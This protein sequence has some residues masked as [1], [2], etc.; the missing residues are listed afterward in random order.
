MI[1]T[2]QLEC[3]ALNLHVERSELA[4]DQLLS[5]ASRANPKRGFLFVSKVL[6]KHI[7]CA[8]SKM[9]EVYDRLAARVGTSASGTLV[10]GMAET[11]TGLG[12]GVAHS[13]SQ[14]PGGAVL[15]Q[16]TT[17]HAL[18]C[19]LLIT[20]DEAHSHAP[21][22]LLYEPLPE[23]MPHYLT[24]TR[25]VLVDD[26]ITTGRTLKE[27]AVALLRKLQ[28]L[29]GGQQLQELVFVSIV[30][31]LSAEQRE[32]LQDLIPAPIRFEALLE[33]SFS[34]VPNP[35]FSPSLPGQIKALD[36][37]TSPRNDLGRRGLLLS[38]REPFE[39]N[40]APL[41]LSE[42]P[43]DPARPVSVIGTGELAFQPFLL[44]EQLEAQGFEVL[45][46][47]TTRSPVLPGAAI[48]RSLHFTDEHGE[49]VSNYLH[50]PPD[51]DRQVIVVYESQR[52]AALH[53]L[54]KRLPLTAWVLPS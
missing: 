54:S 7:P 12:A 24:A 43:L 21:D 47:S 52:S 26:E 5:F 15:S 19:P 48:V 28:A 37:Q 22:Q 46:Q 53:P 50:N 36:A 2:V 42:L 38:P 27:L 1:Q 9:R 8:P 10:I 41:A 3:G 23:L 11:A 45:Y 4:L 32:A 31:W 14:L 33:G 20:F 44:A 13:L 49:G 39:L 30:S 40:R 25:V 18:P 51:A 17:R 16:H 34:Y 6:G 35:S 29:T